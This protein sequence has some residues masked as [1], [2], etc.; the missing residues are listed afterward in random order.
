MHCPCVVTQVK[1]LEKDGYEALQLGYEEQKE[2]HTTKPELGHFKKAGVTPKRHL[3]EFKGFEGEYKL[4]D[5]ITVDGLFAENDFVDIAGTSKGK[6]YQGVVKRH[7]FGGV[8]QTTHGQHNRLRAPG[9][10]GACSYPAKVFKGMRMAGQTGNKRVTVQNLQVLKVIAEHNL[11]MIKG[12]IP[13]SKGSIVII[14]K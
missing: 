7:G 3:A 12:S 13:G 6:G 4:G 1:T 14:E 8:G 2:K 9:S 10:V 5:T 11:L